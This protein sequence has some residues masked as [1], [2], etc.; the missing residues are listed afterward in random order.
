[1][2]EFWHGGL[3]WSVDNTCTNM[4]ATDWHGV[5]GLG[6]SSP[7]RGPKDKSAIKSAMCE[8]CSKP[9]RHGDLRQEI[10]DVRE[11]CGK[12]VFD[13]LL[14]ESVKSDSPLLARKPK[15]GRSS[16]AWY[17]VKEREQLLDACLVKPVKKDVPQKGQGMR[18]LVD[19]VVKT[20]HRLL[21][22]ISESDWNEK[23]MLAISRKSMMLE[24]EVMKLKES[25]P[26]L[27]L[28]VEKTLK[29]VNDEI[30]FQTSLGIKRPKLKPRLRIEEMCDWQAHWIEVLRVL[31]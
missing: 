2:H 30:A 16:E 25:Y 27:S 14:K 7:K 31:E 9:V 28:W 24:G 29:R 19:H 23:G 10:V 18:F 8:I 20:A 5:N 26:A 1:V 17:V 11:L 13:V 4:S 15:I 21:D 12:T 22:E 6:K 3:I